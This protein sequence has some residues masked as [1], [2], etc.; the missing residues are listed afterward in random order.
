MSLKDRLAALIAAGG[1][2]TVAEFMHACLHDPREGYYATRPDLGAKGDFVTAPLVSQMFGEL[3]GLWAVETWRALGAPD[4]FRLVEVGP[5]DGTLMVD[6]LRAARLVPEFLAACDLW[7]VEVSEPLLRRQMAALAGASLTPTFVQR[8]ADIPEGAP[9]IVV[10]NEFLDCLPA[11]QF[12]QNAAGGWV[13][14]LVGLDDDGDLTFALAE[15][16]AAGGLVLEVSAA[17]EAFGSELGMVIRRET[18]A[19]LLIDY[20]R[21]ESGFGDTFQALS[22]HAKVDPLEAPGSADLTVHADFPTVLTAA[23]DEGCETEITTQAT[24]LQRL[25]IEYRAA[26]LARARPER[27]EAL[28]RQLQRLIAPDQMGELFKAA[29]IHYPADPIPPGFADPA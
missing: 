2:M 12:V 5:G 14:R 6:L 10:A 8:L 20:G 17:Q 1:P 24:F 25:G 28:E 26:S 23:A 21:S 16:V 9:V 15:P 3:I 7:L 4:R 29:C 22:R 18:G 11:R 27:S 13:E 19:A